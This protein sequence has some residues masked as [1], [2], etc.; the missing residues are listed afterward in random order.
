VPMT[1]AAL[2]GKL[3]LETLDGEEII[4]VDPGTQSGTVK[5]LRRRGVPRLQ[6]QGRGDLFVELAVETPS[7]LSDEERDLLRRLAQLRGDPVAQPT[8]ASF[9]SKLK[10]R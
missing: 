3:A 9:F 2:G 10:S 5:R 8:A 6:A 7:D 4:R 1:V